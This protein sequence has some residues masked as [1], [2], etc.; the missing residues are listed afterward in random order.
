MLSMPVYEYACQ[1][2]GEHFEVEQ[3]M[4]DDPIKIH[5][6][7]GGD[8]LKVFSSAGI[9]LKGSGFYKTDARSGS[10]TS[11]TSTKPTS[12]STKKAEPEK[13]KKTETP[14]SKP[15]ADPKP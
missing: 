15:K 3:K 5:E 6:T 2:C 1:K 13:P 11:K 12:E 9:V 10:S 7:C 14:A 4:T 8:V